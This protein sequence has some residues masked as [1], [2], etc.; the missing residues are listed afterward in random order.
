MCKKML[1]ERYEGTRKRRKTAI[2]NEE[3]EIKV[4]RE[5]RDGALTEITD[6]IAQHDIMALEKEIQE[7]E[8]ELDELED[9]EDREKLETEIFGEDDGNNE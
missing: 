3:K 1:I 6:K 2:E 8:E 7:C 5:R 9:L 4:E